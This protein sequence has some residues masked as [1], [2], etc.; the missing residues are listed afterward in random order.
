MVGTVLQKYLASIQLKAIMNEPNAVLRIFRNLFPCP[1]LVQCSN[2][3]L[4]TSEYW[5]TVTVKPT[6]WRPYVVCS[7]GGCSVSSDCVQCWSYLLT[8]IVW[9]QR[10]VV[11]AAVL[12]HSQSACVF[13]RVKAQEKMSRATP[14]IPQSGPTS[15]GLHRRYYRCSILS[16]LQAFLHSRAVLPVAT[17]PMVLCSIDIYSFSF[18]AS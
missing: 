9:N 5:S 18:L 7:V 17:F 4:D 10:K 16:L 8:D 11:V 12:Y 2:T 6:R 13:H 3:R 1:H 15:R 14:L